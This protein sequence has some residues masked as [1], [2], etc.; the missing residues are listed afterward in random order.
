MANMIR[1]S[2]NEYEKARKYAAAESRSI[3]K[4]IEY[5]AKIGRNCILN[6]DLT[7]NEVKAILEASEEKQIKETESYEFKNRKHQKIQFED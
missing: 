3:S 4:Q 6:P 1:L 5:W 7:A 2:E